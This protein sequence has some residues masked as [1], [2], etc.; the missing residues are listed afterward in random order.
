VAV[1][2]NAVKGEKEKCL[3]AGMDDYLTKPFKSVDLIPFLEKYLRRSEGIGGTGEEEIEELVEI[4]DGDREVFDHRE[5]LLTFMG[6]AD[7][8]DRVV[9]A[10]RKKIATQ[11]PEMRE[12]LEKGLWDSLRVTSHGIKG[13]SWNLQARRLGN[14]AAELEQASKEQDVQKALDALQK[15]EKEFQLFEQVVEGW[16]ERGPKGVATT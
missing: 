16:K 9:E 8:V 10:F 13:G 1:T 5:A 14:A 2:A 12:A 15:V 6:K 3:E 11:I 4:G 7:V